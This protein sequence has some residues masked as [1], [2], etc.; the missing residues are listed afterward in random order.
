[1]RYNLGSMR[2]SPSGKASAFQADIRG[3]ESRCPLKK[4][5]KSLFLSPGTIEVCYSKS[6]SR[7]RRLVRDFYFHGYHR[8]MIFEFRCAF[9]KTRK[10]LFLLSV[11]IEGSADPTSCYKSFDPLS[12]HIPSQVLLESQPLGQVLLADF[13]QQASSGATMKKVKEW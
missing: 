9:K 1:M 13:L 3:F 10:S 11:T 2:A 6:T 7:S 5:R 8:G 12:T 4:T